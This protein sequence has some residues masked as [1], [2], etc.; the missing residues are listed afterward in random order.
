[1]KQDKGGGETDKLKKCSR[2]TLP[3]AILKWLN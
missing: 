1:M 3:A 2:M